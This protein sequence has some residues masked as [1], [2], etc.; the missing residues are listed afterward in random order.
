M[1]KDNGAVNIVLNSSGW[2]RDYRRGKEEVLRHH[3]GYNSVDIIWTKVGIIW[4]LRL[5]LYYASAI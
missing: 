5:I 4:T 1:T 2:P 3:H